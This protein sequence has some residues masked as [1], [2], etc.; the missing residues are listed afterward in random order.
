MVTPTHNDQ[1]RLLR[2]PQ[3]EGEYDQSHKEDPGECANASEV[4]LDMSVIGVEFRASRGR[5][6]TYRSGSSIA[7]I[8]SLRHFFTPFLLVL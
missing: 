5:C 1:S 7:S 6:H 8:C 4:T 3:E 2:L